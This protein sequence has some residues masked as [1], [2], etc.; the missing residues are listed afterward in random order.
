MGTKPD[1]GY[2]IDRIDNNKGYCKDNCRWATCKEQNN[3]KRNNI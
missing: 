2:S 1:T 3:N